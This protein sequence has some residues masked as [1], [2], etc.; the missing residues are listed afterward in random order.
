MYWCRYHETI[1]GCLVELPFRN[2]QKGKHEIWK[3]TSILKTY[4]L[5]RGYE[6]EM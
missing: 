6:T 4:A 3:Q 2:A 5:Q 1:T